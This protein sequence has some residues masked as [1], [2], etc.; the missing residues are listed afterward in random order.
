MHINYLFI[1][2][3]KILNLTRNKRSWILMEIFSCS[4]FGF[5]LVGWF[6]FVFFFFGIALSIFLWK[7]LSL[8]EGKV[9]V[10]FIFISPGPNSVNAY[11]KLNW[12]HT[13][14]VVWVFSVSFCH[15]SLISDLIQVDSFLASI[16]Q[17]T[18]ATS[19][20]IK[21]STRMRKSVPVPPVHTK[22]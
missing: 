1:I 5:C 14:N 16:T 21:H 20:G 2:T 9:H 6:W 22:A 7:W 18:L 10:L 4:N 17:G 3:W 15:N 12:I 8:P 19:V 13:L 11:I